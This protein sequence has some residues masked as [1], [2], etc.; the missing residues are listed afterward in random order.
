MDVRVR[1]LATPAERKKFIKLQWRFYRDDPNWVPPLLFDRR[2]L[3]D[4]KK[5][6]FFR[7][8][9]MQLFIAERD[10]VPAG[11]IAA[12]TNR[13]HN[14]VHEDTVGFFGFFEC[15]DDRAVAH[16]LFDAA[17]VWL[18]EHGMT[19]MRG[20]LNPSINDEVGLLVDGFGEP[21]RLLMP[22]NPFYYIPL[23]ESYGF[24]KEMDLYA[25]ALFDESV[26][27]PKL[28]R[29]QQL[30]RERYRLTIRALD[31]KRLP[32]EI[33]RVREIYNAAWEKN[34]GAVA[35]TDEEFTALGKDLVQVLGD[36]KE[37]AMFLEMDGKPV[38]FALALPDIN[39]IL[40]RNRRGWLIPGA[41][42]LLTGTKKISWL[43]IIVLGI[44]PSYRGRGFDSVLYH[45]IVTRARKRGVHHG[46][47]SWVLEDNVMMNRGAG[48][49]NGTRYKT[50]RVY[51]KAI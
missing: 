2:K 49:M 36:F 13:N 48:L 3:L 10:G 11:R 41:I 27:N 8:G 7:H 38:G 23:I 33:A 20:P 30:V 6:P 34:W 42:R 32:E 18:K 9:D 22:Y 37:F 39:Q 24:V 21:A 51:Q 46:E 26:L 12:I 44:L 19:A 16:A 25:Y 43:R 50:Y 15:I 31:L 45:E 47:A 29:G 5:N 1:A 17:G 28:E 35:M 4:P 40:I 14:E